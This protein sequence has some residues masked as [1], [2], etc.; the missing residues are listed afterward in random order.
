MVAPA[1][2]LA[3]DGVTTDA[4]GIYMAR[5]FG[6]ALVEL[7]LVIFLAR[8]VEDAAAQRAI[9]LGSCIGSLAGLGVALS[10]QLSRAVNALGWSMV[11]IYL[12]LVAGLWLLRVHPASR[13]WSR[14][15]VARSSSGGVRGERAVRFPSGARVLSCT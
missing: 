7:G 15:R 11:A 3:P 2:T 9:V 8:Q 1:A 5:Y 10:A 6:T 12:F 4:A 13:W 14:T